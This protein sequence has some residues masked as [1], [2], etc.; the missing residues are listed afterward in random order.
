MELDQT[1]GG[2]VADPPQSTGGSRTLVR[3]IS[4]LAVTGALL[5]MGTGE[6]WTLERLR[7]PGKA[8]VAGMPTVA[9]SPRTPRADLARI[10]AVLDP[11]VTR[12]AAAL[13]VSRQA[14]YKWDKGDPVSLE[15]A[16]KLHDLAGAADILDSAGIKVDATILNRRFAGGKTLLQ[17][18]QAGGS[19]REAAL[20]LV[21]IH[22]ME[23]E[24]RASMDVLFRG[25]VRT[26]DSGDF[27]LPAA[28]AGELG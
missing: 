9:I 13:G 2:W 22:Q 15:N 6:E 17:V 3:C 28:D 23:A 14:I 10:L 7:D 8:Q 20:L 5:A 18:V 27:D 21:Q 26:A 11:A 12:L 25:R 4:W 19:A 16:D 24:Q 1:Y